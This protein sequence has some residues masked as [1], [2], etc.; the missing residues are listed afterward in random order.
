[1]KA[2]VDHEARRDAAR[3]VAKAIRLYARDEGV[4]LGEIADAIA[5]SEQSFYAKLKG[6]AP[7]GLEELNKIA[8]VLKVS[9]RDL[10]ADLEIRAREPISPGEKID[11]QHA[12]AA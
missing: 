7:F 8:A 4:T 1:M 9:A 6:S 10:L 12:L 5:I 2:Y 11:S 3:P